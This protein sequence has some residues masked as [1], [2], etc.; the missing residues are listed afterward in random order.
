MAA[1]ARYKSSKAQA[2]LKEKLLTMASYAE[3]AV[4]HAVRALV[5]RDDQLARRTREEDDRIDALEKEIDDVALRLLA[6]RPGAFDLRFITTAM[7]ISQNLER[8]GDEA[9]TISRRVIQLSGE[10]QLPMADAIPPMAVQA[11]R[12][13]KGAL[14]A[15]V[16]RDPAKARALIPEDKQVD[17][18]NKRLHLELTALMTAKPATIARS[19]HLMVICKSLERIADHATNVAEEVVYLYEGRDIRHQDLKAAAPPPP[20]A[21]RHPAARRSRNS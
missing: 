9:T 8:V 19:L 14:D 18:M 3:A 13:L 2:G 15:F 6:R 17:A 11:L 5:R 4:N 1:P 7:K 12:L 21:S 20:A 16:H 10:P